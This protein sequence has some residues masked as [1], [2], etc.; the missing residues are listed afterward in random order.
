MV[1][2]RCHHQ[3]G[4]LLGST[5]GEAKCQF[6]IEPTLPCKLQTYFIPLPHYNQTHHGL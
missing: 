4:Y 5:L 1:T 3:I 2:I 6:M